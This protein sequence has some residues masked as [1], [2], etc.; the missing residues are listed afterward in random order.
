M[1]TCRLAATRKRTSAAAL[2]M[3]P[4]TGMA[5]SIATLIATSAMAADFGSPI[6]DQ[7]GDGQAIYL[8]AIPN[9]GDQ[10]NADA[11]ISL[12]LIYRFGN[13]GARDQEV[14]A[15][16]RNTAPKGRPGPLH[17]DGEGENVIN[18]S[19][20]GCVTTHAESGIAF[21]VDCPVSQSQLPEWR[22]EIVAD[23]SHFDGPIVSECRSLYG[24]IR[25]FACNPRDPEC[26]LTG[27]RTDLGDGAKLA[28]L[29]SMPWPV[30]PKPGYDSSWAQASLQ[31]PGCRL[32]ALATSSMQFAS[33]GR[34][35]NARPALVPLPEWKCRIVQDQSHFDGP[36]VSVCQRMYNL[37][38][39][40]E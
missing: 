14:A 34:P 39:L 4:S 6:I 15:W 10:G 24:E 1:I 17:E 36:I 30:H 26:H 35:D 16:S 32:A 13:G 3:F 37:L 12:G 18:A 31:W 29:V 25:T 33:C 19:Q 20:S 9:F 23:Q 40:R 2:Q 11:Q 8:R 22:C 21:S 27:P 38:I 28:P 7:D 5:I